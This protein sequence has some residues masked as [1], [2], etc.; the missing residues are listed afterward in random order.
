MEEQDL[1][2][3]FQAKGDQ[4]CFYSRRN[5]EQLLYLLNLKTCVW[6]ALPSL[7]VFGFLALYRH[8][9]LKGRLCFATHVI[10]ILIEFMSK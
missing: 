9:L 5:V 6:S 8:H 3:L 4:F 7:N 2:I 1:H 10:N